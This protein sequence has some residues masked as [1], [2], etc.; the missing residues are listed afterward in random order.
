MN[1][2]PMTVEKLKDRGWDIV[3]VSEIMDQSIK[4]LIILGYAREHDRIIIT[5]D[6]DFSRLLA[7]KGFRKPSLINLRLTNPT[8]E[9]VTNRVI[10]VVESLVD[11]LQ[12]GI[13]VSVDE[14]SIRYRTL[15]IKTE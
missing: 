12:S 15:P 3:R 11:E 14:D 1:I 2:S 13:V 7:I 8:P 6:L 9:L 5:Q 10:E 4:D